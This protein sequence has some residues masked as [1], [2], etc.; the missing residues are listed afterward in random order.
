[1][2]VKLYALSTCPYCNMTKKFLNEQGCVY[3]SVDVDLV[4]K[5]E[6]SY[7]LSEVDRLTGKRSFP[8][9]LINDQV[10]QGDNPEAILKALHSE[11]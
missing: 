1:M 9:I 5:E 4:G 7:I 2:T 6:A 11:E 10:I 8:V 3:E